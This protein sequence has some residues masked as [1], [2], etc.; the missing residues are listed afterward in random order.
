MVA[1]IR[2]VGE[3]EKSHYKVNLELIL[4]ICVIVA[5]FCVSWGVLNNRITSLEADAMTLTTNTR[6]TEEQLHEI[7]VKLTEVSTDIKWIK[8]A[9]AQAGD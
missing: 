4:S 1:C 2:I 6:I 5:T 8:K 9:L 7:C 3:K